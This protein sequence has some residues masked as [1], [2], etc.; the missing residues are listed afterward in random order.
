M[1][2]DV[3]ISGPGDLYT[4]QLPVLIVPEIKK[5]VLESNAQKIFIC[6]IANKPFETKD[7]TLS[8]FIQAVTDHMGAFPFN[9]V[10]ANNNFS[11][12]IPSAY[13]YTYVHTDELSRNGNN[14][15]R[16]IEEDV[17]NEAFPLYH[18]Q[19]KLASI[20]VKNI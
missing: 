17:V 14:S 10:L 6:N 2:A 5:A 13:K 12:S 1:S 15:Y 11:V 4:N 9:T 16:V 20:I 8:D 7:F 19:T 3:I 18:D